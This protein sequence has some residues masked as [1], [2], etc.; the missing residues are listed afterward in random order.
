MRPGVAP[1]SRPDDAV[2]TNRV[3]R[4]LGLP[5]LNGR[6]RLVAAAVID[7][8]GEGLFLPMALFFFTVSTPLLISRIGLTMS[9]ATILAF[10]ASPVLGALTDRSGPQRAVVLS[11]LLTAAGYAFYPA[12]STYPGIFGCVLVVMVADRL[13]YASWPT[14]LTAIARKGELDAWFA[15]SQAL[16]KGSFGMG[17]LLGSLLIGDGSRG[18]L[19]VLIYLDVT[20]C[21]VAAVLTASIRLRPSSGPARSSSAASPWNEV[22]RDRAFRRIVAS[23]LLLAFA[24]AVPPVFLPLYLVRYLGLPPWQATLAFGVNCM[25]IFA[26]QTWVTRMVQGFR[27][28]RAIVAGA[29]LF[30]AALL[31]F[32]AASATSA[33]W[34]GVIV[35]TG[36]VVFTAGE[37]LCTP[38]FTA[39]AAAAAPSH[40]RGQYMSIF[41]LGGGVG[42]G[43]GP[44]LVGTLYEVSPYAALAGL[45]ACV[46]AGGALLQR[47]ERLL[48]SAAVQ[49]SYDPDD[50]HGR[51]HAPG[52]P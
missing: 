28:T 9:L 10:A 46:A 13:Y 21:L 20:T 47:S 43:L 17:A 49:L 1:G 19:V 35:L 16:A 18:P 14:L 36:M 50:R 40:L 31:V 3:A 7:T 41:G 29:V 12:V 32:A 45:G 30:D 51:D 34:A 25:L 4:A 39:L 27:R 23:Q 48:P 33:Q 15:L 24:W 8:L 42:F 26:G 44:G 5:D 11:N 22:R 52:A 6:G 38:S 2:G 37:M